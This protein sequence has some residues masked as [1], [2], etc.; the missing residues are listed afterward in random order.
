LGL[1]VVGLGSSLS[2]ESNP[3]LL[4]LLPDGTTGGR[5]TLVALEDGADDCLEFIMV[6]FFNDDELSSIVL[7]LD[8]FNMP[9]GSTDLDRLLGGES[10]G[11]LLWLLLPLPWLLLLAS[12]LLRADLT[13]ESN[14]LVLIVFPSRTVVGG[15]GVG[16]G[17]DS[18]KGL[19]LL[20]LLVLC[21]L[22]S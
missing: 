1:L 21:F 16:R 11:L 22:S 10:N 2:D 18:S 7:I 20:L 14:G 17:G 12:D 8:R 3:L 6:G 13:G 9:D 5:L 19:L 15:V 4:L